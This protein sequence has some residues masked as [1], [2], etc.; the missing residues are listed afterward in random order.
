MTY[1]YCNLK[2]FRVAY[3]Q[4]NRDF[5]NIVIQASKIFFHAVFT[6]Y[7]SQQDL[8]TLDFWIWYIA[9]PNVQFFSHVKLTW[10]EVDTKSFSHISRKFK[11]SDPKRKGVQNYPTKL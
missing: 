6:S 11:V 1:Q 8:S 9:P 3:L 2:V 7:V 4:K 5:Q 10:S